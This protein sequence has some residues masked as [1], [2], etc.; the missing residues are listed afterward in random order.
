MQTRFMIFSFSFTSGFCTARSGSLDAGVDRIRLPDSAPLPH[1]GD[2]ES[3]HGYKICSVRSA[4][5]QLPEKQEERQKVR[6][7]LFLHATTRRGNSKMVF[8]APFPVFR[9][10][11]LTLSA[12]L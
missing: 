2:G 5:S 11:G 12:H 1:R 7:A 4:S 3:K 6:Y 9:R 8:I 10:V